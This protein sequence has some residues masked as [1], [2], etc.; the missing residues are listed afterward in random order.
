MSGKGWVKCCLLFLVILISF[1]VIWHAKAKRL[2]I[3]EI[4]FCFFRY[5]TFESPQ[6]SR[7]KGCTGKQYRY[8]AMITTFILSVMFI[9]TVFAIINEH[10]VPTNSL[11][12]LIHVSAIIF[13][14]LVYLA[15]VAAVIACRWPMIPLTPVTKQVSEVWMADLASNKCNANTIFGT[16][17]NF[18]NDIMNTLP[19]GYR[20]PIQRIQLGSLNSIKIYSFQRII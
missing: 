10:V 17:L 2:A 12:E 1:V 4:S 15:C 16:W 5:D 3:T 9:A 18:I 8:F 19:V 6:K 13:A 11:T 7:L 20:I 14:Y